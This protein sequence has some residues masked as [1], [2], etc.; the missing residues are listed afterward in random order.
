M[1][2]EAGCIVEP[3]RVELV[4]RELEMSNDAVLVRVL[5]NGICGS[6]VSVFARRDPEGS[7]PRWIGHEG[8]G[9]VEEVGSNVVG[10][11]PGDQVTGLWGA[12]APYAVARD[13]HRLIKI[14]EDIG[15]P[16]Q[17]VQ[18]DPLECCTNIARGAS[19]QM[20]DYVALVGCGFMGLMTLGALRGCPVAEFIALDYHDGRL[21]VA[22]E[23]GA[24]V[25]INPKRE[26]AEQRVAELTDGHG[27]DIVIEAVGKPAGLDLASRLLRPV[28]GK[29]IMAGFH[30]VPDT[31]DLSH[32]ARTGAVVHSTHPNYV[33]D[34]MVNC[35]MGI[36]MLKRGFFPV[37]KLMTHFMP[38]DDL[39][40][41]FEMA[42]EQGEGFIKA[43][44]VF[45]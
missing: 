35:R 14:P 23:V 44:I 15:V 27:C 41:A 8:V 22:R 45:E 6:E 2:V 20:G 34:P 19:P 33:A 21:D 43:T 36:D 18:G 11:A 16:L 31:Y 28:Q 1:K 40:E 32:W 9:V 13:V 39:Q 12:F 37:E 17:Y 30:V 3:G 7:Y 24:T 4:E 26:D 29:F 25:T 5:A 38:L 42:V 10:F